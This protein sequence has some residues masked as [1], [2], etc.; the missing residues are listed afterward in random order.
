ML[1]MRSCCKIFK[2]DFFLDKLCYYFD[3]AITLMKGNNFWLRLSK[4]IY[5]TKNV[6]RVMVFNATIFQLYRG[7]QFYWRRKHE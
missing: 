7:S 6:K 4:R 1:N 2:C 3:E 5:E